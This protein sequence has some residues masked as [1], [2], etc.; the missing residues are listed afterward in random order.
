MSSEPHAEAESTGHRPL[1]GVVV[2]DFSRVLAG[3][4][5]SMF[6]ADLGATVVK[7]ERPGSGDDTRTWGPPHVGSLSTYFTSVN[8]NKR[9]VVLDLADPDE[10]ELAHTLAS[11]ADV[12]IENFLPG[13]LSAFGLDSTTLLEANPTLIYCSVTGFGSSGGAHLPGYDFV[14]Q[15]VGGLMS[16]TGAEDGEPTKVG[17]A[18]VDVLTGLHATISILAALR[19]RERSGC[20]QLVEV[21]LLSSLIASLANQGAAY[22]NGHPAPTAMG[23]QHPSIAPYETLTTRDHPI[24]VA[25]GNDRQ[26]QTFAEAIGRSELSADDRFSANRARV[27]NRRELIAELETTLK[28]E[29]VGHW[30]RLLQ[31]RGI[32]CGPVNDIAGAIALASELGLDPVASFGAT[33]HATPIATLAS[34]LR[35]SKNPVVYHRPPPQLGADTAEVRDWLLSDG[36]EPLDTAPSPTP[37]LR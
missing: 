12:F 20:G 4:L 34:P 22:I 23:N 36:A 19:E 10:L 8:R 26:F 24:A 11:R 28:A 29:T 13:K 2:A 25:V 15:A 1:D 21:N 3:P 33:P 7:V 30:T 5:A 32:P 27:A 18:L 6:L 31:E 37:R 9:S 14:V 16:I 35:L 17:V